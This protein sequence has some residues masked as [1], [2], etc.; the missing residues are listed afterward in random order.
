MTLVNGE[1]RA[2]GGVVG[3]GVRLFRAERDRRAGPGHAPL[4]AQET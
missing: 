4:P 1:V 3:N 2:E